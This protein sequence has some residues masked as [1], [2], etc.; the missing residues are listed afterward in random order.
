MRSGYLNFVLL[1]FT[2]FYI[3]ILMIIFPESID[4]FTRNLIGALFLLYGLFY[5]IKAFESFGRRKLDDSIRFTFRYSDTEHPDKY[6]RWARKFFF[7]DRHIA[8]VSRIEVEDEVL[9]SISFHFPLNGSDAATHSKIFKSFD[10][11]ENC[12]KEEWDKFMKACF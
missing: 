11:A 9:Y 6:G 4:D 7:R 1:A 3:S 12:I 10:E 5:S 2:H 8:W